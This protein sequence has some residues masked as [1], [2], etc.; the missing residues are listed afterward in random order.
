MAVSPIVNT[1]NKNFAEG[2]E[3]EIIKGES[4]LKINNIGSD[5]DLDELENEDISIIN[6]NENNYNKLLGLFESLDL[7][8]NE[9]EA[10]QKSDQYKKPLKERVKLRGKAKHKN[11]KKKNKTE[12]YSYPKDSD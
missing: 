4:E 9:E 12:T 1:E 10:D 11:N 7:K 2:K 5:D 8:D 6:K 3:N